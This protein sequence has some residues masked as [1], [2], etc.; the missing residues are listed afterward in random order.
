MTTNPITSELLRRCQARQMCS[1]TT[2]AAG[3]LGLAIDAGLVSL[4]QVLDM[5]RSCSSTDELG[6]MMLMMAASVPSELQQAGRVL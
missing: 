4:E 3:A 2:E 5:V 1:A 6:S